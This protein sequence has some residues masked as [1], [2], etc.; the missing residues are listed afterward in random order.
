MPIS[1]ELGNARIYLRAFF[2]ARVIYSLLRL[3]SVHYTLG[4]ETAS[5]V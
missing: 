1:L 4:D 3:P 2:Y 5:W